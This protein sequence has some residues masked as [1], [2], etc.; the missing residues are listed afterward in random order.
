MVKKVA[1]GTV[2]DWARVGS[3]SEAFRPK[4]SKALDDEHFGHRVLEH[5]FR[6]AWPRVSPLRWRWR[7]DVMLSGRG[8]QPIRRGSSRTLTVD[9]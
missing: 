1:E 3:T 9:S 7:K 6:S 5:G 2:E 8:I 4:A